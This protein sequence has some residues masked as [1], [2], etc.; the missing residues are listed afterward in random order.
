MKTVGDIRNLIALNQ[1]C[2]D[3]LGKHAATIEDAR[4]TGSTTT[5]GLHEVP[6]DTP[7]VRVYP[8]HLRKGCECYRFFYKM[9]GRLGAIPFRDAMDKYGKVNIRTG[10]HGPELYVTGEVGDVVNRDEDDIYVI[11]GKHTIRDTDEQVDAVFTWH[12]G[13]PM[14]TLEDGI[15]E[16]TAVKVDIA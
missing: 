7:V 13:E 14:P 15:T 5:L 2:D 1:Q 12:P 10:R 4:T 6:A 8:Q 16:E 9:G 3:E 11:V